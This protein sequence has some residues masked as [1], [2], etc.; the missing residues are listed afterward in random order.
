MPFLFVGLIL[1]LMVL[2]NKKPG[3]AAGA[4]AVAALQRQTTEPIYDIGEEVMLPRY[5][6]WGVIEEAR[7]MSGTW[8]YGVS[9]SHGQRVRVRES[10][11]CE[12]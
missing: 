3:A 10:E 6:D 9:I 4:T 2:A 7:R 12:G 8:V 5:N 1:A 11:V